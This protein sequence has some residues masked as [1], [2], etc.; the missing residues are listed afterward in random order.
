MVSLQTTMSQPIS[1][2]VTSQLRANIEASLRSSCFVQIRSLVCE[3][4]GKVMVL[5]GQVDSYY[6][7]QVAQELA[8]RIDPHVT[9][10]NLVT[11]R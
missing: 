10:A 7:K 2:A 9:I 5:R 4:H 8:K 3:C 11:V 1:D 6:Y